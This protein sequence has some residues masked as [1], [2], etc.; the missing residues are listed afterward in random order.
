MILR[1]YEL[2]Q[3]RF[4]VVWCDTSPVRRVGVTA[5]QQKN[6]A[7]LTLS[8]YFRDLELLFYWR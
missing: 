6:Y 8:L 5:W 2:G 4:T 3:C 7:K 1:Q